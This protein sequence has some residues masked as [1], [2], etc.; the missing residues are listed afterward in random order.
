MSATLTAA[1]AA[2]VSE[3]H[4]DQTTRAALAIVA[5]VTTGR[6]FGSGAVRQPGLYGHE[7]DVVGARQGTY[8]DPSK[9]QGP[10]ARFP[11]FGPLLVVE[12]RADVHEFLDA[13]EKVK[14]D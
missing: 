6:R 2:G 12:S 8:V 5:Q 3:T 9:V 4:D 11:A 7:P 13:L 1:I 10:S 14:L